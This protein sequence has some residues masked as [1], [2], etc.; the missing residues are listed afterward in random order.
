M[1]RNHPELRPRYQTQSTPVE[2]PNMQIL[3]ADGDD[4]MPGASD[5]VRKLFRYPP[6]LLQIIQI[7]YI[8][9]LLQDARGPRLCVH[10][11]LGFTA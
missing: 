5:F 1:I 11:L 3:S 8:I 6:I 7:S 2:E 10:R 9:S 4:G